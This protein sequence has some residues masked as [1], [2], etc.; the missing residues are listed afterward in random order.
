VSPSADRGLRVSGW[1]RKGTSMLEIAGLIAEHRAGW[2]LLRPCRAQL[3]PSRLQQKGSRPASTSAA[4]NSCASRRL[5]LAPP[6]PAC[7]SRSALPARSHLHR[8]SASA[9]CLS[10]ASC[11]AFSD[12]TCRASSRALSAGSCRASSRALSDGNCSAGVLVS[13][14]A[15]LRRSPTGR[16]A[17]PVPSRRRWHGPLAFRR[18]SACR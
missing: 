14:A 15:R 6:T 11:R 8:P 17:R 9:P 5:P 16:P 18:R 13:A 7:A 4:M 1:L 2:Q 3:Q 12:R 10:R